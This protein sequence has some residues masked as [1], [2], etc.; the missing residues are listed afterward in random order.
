MIKAI[1][2]IT[3][4]ENFGPKEKAK[5]NN[6]PSICDVSIWPNT[7][8]SYIS[9]QGLCG[10]PD[11]PHAACKTTEGNGV[12]VERAPPVREGLLSTP[13]F[14]PP[15]NILFNV[16]LVDG[17]N[18]EWQAVMFEGKLFVHVSPGVLP[19]GSKESF[20]KMLEY[21]EDELGVSHVIVSL[22]KNR[23]D[24]ALLVQCIGSF[25]EDNDYGV[26]FEDSCVSPG[27]MEKYTYPPSRS[28]NHNFGTFLKES[29]EENNEEDEMGVFEADMNEGSIPSNLTAAERHSLFVC[30]EDMKAVVKNSKSREELI[31]LAIEHNFDSNA[32][33]NSL[34]SKKANALEPQSA[35]HAEKKPAVQQN[36]QV[37]RKTLANLACKQN[38]MSQ[39]ESTIN[40]SKQS[41]SVDT[42][43]QSQSLFFKKIDKSP[44]LNPLDKITSQSCPEPS[45]FAVALTHEKAFGAPKFSHHKSRLYTH[46]LHNSIQPFDFLDPSPDDIVHR[47]QKAAFRNKNN[48]SAYR[49]N[50]EKKKENKPNSN[51]P[52]GKKQRGPNDKG[53][54]ATVSSTD[55]NRKKLSQMSLASGE[56][57]SPNPLPKKTHL[58]TPNKLI[59]RK[60]QEKEKLDLQAEYEKRKLCSKG[61]EA[62]NIIVC[63]HVDAGKSTLMGH[64]LV[65]LGQISSKQLHKIKQEATKANRQSFWLAFVLDELEDERERG[66]TMDIARASFET[67]HKI[68]NILDAPGHKDFIP[69]MI[70]GT[71]Q[72]DSAIMA[73][74]ASPGEFEAG[75]ERSGQTREHGM[76]LRSIGVQQIIVA[77]NKMDMVNWNEE[78]FNYIQQTMKSFFT[79]AGIKEKSLSFIPVSGYHGYNLAERY[80]DECASWY[81]GPTLLEQIDSFASPQ[82]KIDAPF[83]MTVSDAFKGSG[84]NVM[85]EGR[86]FTGGVQLHNRL[87]L[88]PNNDVAVVKE[89]QL[90]DKAVPCAFAGDLVILA[91][92]GIELNAVYKGNAFSSPERPMKCTNC[93]EGRIVV[94]ATKVPITNG[95]TVE[96][97]IQ[98]M[99]E[100]AIIKKLYKIVNQSSGETIKKKPR[101]LVAQQTADVLIEI[102]R[103]APMEEF[104]EVSELGRFTLRSQGETI[105]AGI[106]TKLLEKQK[107]SWS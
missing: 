37:K 55:E 102:S 33:L 88:L 56:S 46:P 15:S 77:I 68:V 44:V 54:V 107:I 8:K 57:A 70:S 95:F 52:P 66:V 41:L 32:A 24:R 51:R 4:T 25:D 59:S 2:A 12:G 49:T 10:V 27:T 96:L 98:E 105:G 38:Q 85:I 63:G 74:D 80:N 58:S 13:Q 79:K 78:R 92:S 40:E 23:K 106:I 36:Q 35:V 18:V 61:K 45:S 53:N 71:A 20:V 6:M 97:H 104:K 5:E 62:L 3:N 75:Y 9:V 101:I 84:S 76:L 60:S 43:E 17:R 81:K 34:F 29:I 19:D 22:K 91:L 16:Q 11:A 47:H 50:T 30:L 21:A 72:A 73:V 28:T 87:L 103:S 26:S 90:N 94:F 89:I 42:R 82:R 86:I 69:K 93:F 31:S 14:L 1:K 39:S 99:C 64:L 100:P 65:K 7:T 48:V 67:D 83:R